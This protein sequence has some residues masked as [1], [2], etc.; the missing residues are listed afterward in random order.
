MYGWTPK[1]S[2]EYAP[3]RLPSFGSRSIHRSANARWI[4]A[5]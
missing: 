3:E 1:T 4:V 2:F 5:A